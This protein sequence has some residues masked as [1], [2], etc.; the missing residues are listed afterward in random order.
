MQHRGA[1]MGV[2]HAY[3]AS[4]VATLDTDRVP[5]AEALSRSNMV[6]DRRRWR[7]GAALLQLGAVVALTRKGLRCHTGR[8]VLLLGA[9]IRARPCGFGFVVDAV[10]WV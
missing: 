6:G 2:D 8:H 9:F 10:V 7:A 1:Q 4:R 5:H 3:L